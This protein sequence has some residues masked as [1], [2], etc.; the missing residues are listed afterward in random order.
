MENTITMT[1]EPTT[2]NQ[3]YLALIDAGWDADEAA[4]I[5]FEHC[6]AEDSPKEAFAVKDM[7]SANWVLRKVKEINDEIFNVDAMAEDEIVE[8]DKKIN[9]IRDRA[10]KIKAPLY[11]KKEFFEKAYYPQ[12]R[13]WLSEHLKG[14]KKRSEKLINGVVGFTKQQ[15]KIELE[16]TE[17][18][19]TMFLERAGRKDLI[20]VIP[21][22]HKPSMS[23]IKEAMKSDWDGCVR[24]DDLGEVKIAK[25]KQPEDKFYVEIIQDDID[26]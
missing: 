20:R 26:G 4:A 14:K 5:I 16:V 23:A 25:L 7:S 9:A 18:A 21:E 24:L 11:R 6:C 17:D 10:E 15:P 1:Q 3:V 19:A 2:E 12:I 13:T 22:V 8:L